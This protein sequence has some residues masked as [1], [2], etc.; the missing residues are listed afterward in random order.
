M[1]ISG[2]SQSSRR[3][4][5]IEL[6]ISYAREDLHL[7]ETPFGL[8][9]DLAGADPTGNIG[10]PALP[11]RTIRV[12]LPPLTE[13]TRVQ[14]KEG[15]PDY[16]T[17]GTVLI[18]PL[19]PP[20]PGISNQEYPNA[21]PHQDDEQHYPIRRATLRQ[22]TEPATEPIP[23]PSLAP[24]NPDLYERELKKPRPLA[25]HV[26]TEE[27]GLA[28]VAV[29]EINPV[30]LTNDHV[31]VFCPDFEIV[32]YYRSKQQNQLFTSV[33]AQGESIAPLNAI[34][35]RA[36]AHR[37][38]ELARAQVINPDLVPDFTDLFPELSLHVD[39][40]IITDDQTWD[41]QTITPTG[42]AGN[43]V[44]TF[45]RLADWK[46]KRGLR[47][48]VVT[49]SKIVNG[50][51]GNFTTGARDLQEV[52]RGFLK[53]AYNAWGISW[54]LLG[55][56]IQIIPVR[57]VAGAIQGHIYLQTDDNLPSDNKSY[58]TG[59]YLRMKVVNPGSW[60]PGNSVNHTLVRPD[61]GM[62]I[63]YDATGSSNA[64]TR[65]WYFTTD[66]SYSTRSTTATQY[67][68]VN[69]S[70]TD[71][72]ATLQWLYKWNTLPT[73]LYYASLVGPNYNTPNR[74]DWDLLDNGIYG[75]H[76]RGNDFDGVSY[77]PDISV[78]RAPVSN[79]SQV[80]AFVNKVIAYEQYRQPDDTPLDDNW[81]RRL[82][83]LSSNWV[84]RIHVSA[85]SANPPTDNCYYHNTG[86]NHS[87]I[88]LAKLPEDMQ[89][90]LIVQVTPTDNRVTPY[91]RQASANSRGWHYAQSASN[92]TPSEISAPIWKQTFYFPVPTLWVVVYG[93]P[94]E[95]TPHRYIFDRADPD[96]S[97]TD[98]EILREQIEAELPA[99]NDIS[100]LYEDE[101]DLTP[102]Q[103][104]A[105]P[106][107]HISSVAVQNNLN[108]G[109]HFV[110]L[111][112]HG[113]SNR[114][115]YL[116]S[117]MA[118]TL[119][120]GYHS[121]IG[122]ADSCLTNQF[123][124]E[125][126]VS[127]YLLQNANG[128]AVAYIG[129]TRF[130]WTGVGDNFQRKF[131]NRLTSTRHLGL[132]NDIRGS[133]VNEESSGYRPFNKWVIFTLNLMGDPEMPVWLGRPHQMKVTFPTVVDKRVPFTVSVTRRLV[134]ANVPLAGA[135]VHIQQGNFTRH[136]TTDGR[137]QATFDL[138]PAHL[139]ELE[140]TITA[141]QYKP[142]IGT[143]RITGPAWVQGLVTAVW[144]QQGN[145]HQT[146]IRLQLDQA[147]D[148][149][150]HRG[151]YVRDTHPDY[152][153]ILDAATDAYTSGK[154][155][156]L[157]VNKDGL[158]EKFRFGHFVLALREPLSFKV[159]NELMFETKHLTLDYNYL[160]PDG[161]EIRLLPEMTKGSFA[162]CSLP[163]KAV[164]SPVYHRT[165]EEIW[166]FLEG[167]GQVW[168]KQG[169]AEEVVD[170]HAGVSLT[171]PTGTQFQFRNTGNST[172]HFV[173]ATMPPWP[174]DRD[175][176]VPVSEGG[177]PI[178]KEK[179]SD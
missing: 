106:I 53:W 19:Q 67:V 72:N 160:A 127:E 58:W 137:G 77:E 16:L 2:F 167:Q 177:W 26:A 138:N 60:W 158:V 125:D 5:K 179:D 157:Y 9:V 24:P 46:T 150:A 8:V 155:L 124:A 170:V 4:Q 41:E 100:R 18:A 146:L 134:F 70:A 7:M 149:D 163:V 98:Q 92:L 93:P 171:I 57:Q 75:Q 132:A 78:G 50:D 109:P 27:I 91:N 63:P 105:A 143:T 73:D 151:W 32:I 49:I 114:C 112:G 139:G 34:H 40:L 79:T 101:V 166:Y 175:E 162:H 169:D 176:A 145:A 10:G 86:D 21:P 54:V 165:V 6:K 122:Y 12:A 89:W 130:S 126:A 55:G 88:K 13:V 94:E 121:F 76:D 71:I 152:H 69:G 118:Q 135:M 23:A 90:R 116:D 110:S 97:M 31:L 66:D 104:A 20:R 42:N 161:S 123:D 37:L 102:D 108:A 164:S 28:P 45:Q 68:R 153:A 141:L 154:K 17:E 44:A 156:V 62:L 30:Q 117:S 1:K 84:R 51:Y 140:V 103:T 148:G 14:Y 29:I 59:S 22:P 64:T 99:I 52:I 15:K 174:K 129:N 47:T 85:T 115:C 178:S 128:G 133:M 173:I 81:P 82:L 61:T 95:L 3:S 96:G 147:I 111:S 65:G 119:T 131:F 80:E 43:L 56:D 48:R 33:S 172:L 36:Q 11:S 35:S 87:L 38:V 142:F 74:H 136:A 107:T 83:I 120:N 25:R 159:A 113:D 168:R 144:H 39:Y